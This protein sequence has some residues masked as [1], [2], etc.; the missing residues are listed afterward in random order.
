MIAPV[1]F[2]RRAPFAGQGVD[3]IISIL[4]TAELNAMMLIPVLVYRQI[5][6]QMKAGN[7]CCP[8]HASTSLSKDTL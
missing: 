4:R 1:N 8:S 5:A 3:S 7:I 6:D 2:A